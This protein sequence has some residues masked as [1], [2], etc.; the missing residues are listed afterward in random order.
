MRDWTELSMSS[1]YK[2][3]ARLEKDGLVLRADEVSPDNR[4]RK[5]YTISEGGKK[6][7][8]EKLVGLLSE[9]EQLRWGG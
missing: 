2:L 8:R 7:L 9:P 3:L 1:I 5:Q 6:A 4:I